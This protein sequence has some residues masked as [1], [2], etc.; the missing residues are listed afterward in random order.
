MTARQLFNLTPSVVEHYAKEYRNNGTPPYSD[1]AFLLYCKEVIGG[2]ERPLLPENWQPSSCNFDPIPHGIAKE[3]Y[4]PK[5]RQILG[6][7]PLRNGNFDKAFE[8]QCRLF[9]EADS[10]NPDAPSATF[11]R[12][13]W[14]PKVEIDGID[15]DNLALLIA[16]FT[17]YW[18]EV[19]HCRNDWDEL[20][21]K[22]VEKYLVTS[23]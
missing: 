21:V 19:G 13:G 11:M 6:G 8:E 15:E 2:L 14:R 22:Y 10:R 7:K 1:R 20:L 9:W 17:L 4:L 3:E 18:S 5:F 23:G 16:E 12:K